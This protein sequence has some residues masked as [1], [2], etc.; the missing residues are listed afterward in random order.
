L[1]LSVSSLWVCVHTQWTINHKR[2]SRQGS[3]VFPAVK[4]VLL[5][6]VLAG[7]LVVATSVEATP[8]RNTED[9]HSSP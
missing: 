3:S 7:A 5:H 2:Q 1:L 4:N 8:R 9:A 6:Q